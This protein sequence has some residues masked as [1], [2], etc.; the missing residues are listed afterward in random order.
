MTESYRKEKILFRIWGLPNNLLSGLKCTIPDHNVKTN[1][2]VKDSG[3]KYHDSVV[4][5]FE[6]QPNYDYNKLCIFLLNNKITE[7]SYGIWIS[8]VTER[9]NDGIHLPD[10][11]L[12]F[13]KLIG[14]NIDFSFV[15][16]DS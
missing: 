9:D 15:R 5:L 3:Y 14:G 1:R 6:L 8:L 12:K 2:D 13:Y 10:Y 11:A 7:K 16:T 4:V